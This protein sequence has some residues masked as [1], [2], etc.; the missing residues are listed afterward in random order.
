LEEAKEYYEKGVKAMDSLL[1][2]PTATAE[3]EEDAAAGHDSYA[4]LLEELGEKDRAAQER[5]RAA[6]LREEMAGEEG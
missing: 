1:P 2:L 5:E 6:R 4:L 3:Q